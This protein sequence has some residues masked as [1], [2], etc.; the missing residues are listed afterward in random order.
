MAVVERAEREV[1]VELG[2]PGASVG[3]SGLDGGSGM[4]IKVGVAMLCVVVVLKAVRRNSFMEMLVG[5][6]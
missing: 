2:V 6:S 5:R 1:V 4:P 3:V